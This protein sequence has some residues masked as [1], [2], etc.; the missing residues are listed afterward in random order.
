MPKLPIKTQKA[1]E[2]AD[3]TGFGPVPAG[4]Y[5]LRV[6]GITQQAG[7]TD[8]YWAC[9]FEITYPEQY[10]NKRVWDNISLGEKSAWKVRQFF[11]GLGFTLD[12][13]S[14]EL[15]GEE[16][17][18]LLGIGKIAQGKN[19]G[20]ER[21]EVEEYLPVDGADSGDAPDEF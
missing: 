6:K 3:S 5:T 19:A 18:A 13:D 16:V 1:A 21:N 20:K 14:D 11:D 8:P 4:K 15:V 2:T 12:S 17:A 9:E 7:S 10:R